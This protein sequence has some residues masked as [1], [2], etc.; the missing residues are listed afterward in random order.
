MPEGAENTQKCESSVSIDRRKPRLG[1]PLI[2]IIRSQ[3]GRSRAGV[4]IH[5]IERGRVPVA[6]PART[7]ADCFRYR[8]KRS[9]L[10]AIVRPPMDGV[11]T[12][13]AERKGWSDAGVT[14][15]T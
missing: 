7:V 10:P 13:Y 8:N 12:R 5:G 3:E 1:C 2:R 4:S 6:S 11:R 9:S 15:V 14:A